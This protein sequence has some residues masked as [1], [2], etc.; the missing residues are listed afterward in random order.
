MSIVLSK[1][2]PILTLVNCFPDFS[3]NSGVGDKDAAI[4]SG[5]VGDARDRV[6]TELDG[7]TGD[8]DSELSA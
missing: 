2:F 3:H 4:V 1:F 5:L 6:Q 7:R 8:T